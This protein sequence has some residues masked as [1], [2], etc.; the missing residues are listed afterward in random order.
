MGK[1]QPDRRG[2]LVDAFRSGSVMAGAVLLLLLPAA[3]LIQNGVFPEKSLQLAALLC[4]G[5]SGFLTELFVFGKRRNGYM[6]LP[7]SALICS[8]IFL[9]L[10]ACIPKNGWN[11]GYILETMCALTAGMSVVYFM[12]INKNNKKSQ[13]KRK[14]YYK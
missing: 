4:A 3:M 6:F 12:K 2:Q 9:L 13:K 8:L 1:Q 5:L 11:F 7:C 10:G 14:K